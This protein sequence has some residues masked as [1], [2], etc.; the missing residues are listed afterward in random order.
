MH[1]SV[2]YSFTFPQDSF[3]AS[4]FVKYPLWAT[5]YSNGELLFLLVLDSFDP[6]IWALIVT[7]P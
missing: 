6:T 1:D 4:S 2:L 5:I 7:S 3:K